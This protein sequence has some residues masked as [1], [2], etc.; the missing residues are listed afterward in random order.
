ML[1]KAQ[2]LMSRVSRSNWMSISYMPRTRDLS[3]SRRTLIQAWCRKII[4]GNFDPGYGPN[5]NINA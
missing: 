3:A 4:S 5:K 1:T 2:Q